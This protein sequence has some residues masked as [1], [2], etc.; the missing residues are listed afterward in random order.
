MA[1]NIGYTIVMTFAWNF[2]DQAGLNQG[3]ISSLVSF[4]SVFNVIVFYFVF[5]EKVSKL[6]LIGVAFMFCGIACIGAAALSSDDSLVDEDIDTG[7]RS[8]TTNGILALTIGFGG[9]IILSF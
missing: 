4:A 7:G 3:V 6:H 8:K 5:G 9:P 2:A 1:A